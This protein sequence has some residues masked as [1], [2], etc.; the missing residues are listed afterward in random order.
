MSYIPIV[1]ISLADSIA[2]SAIREACRVHG[3]FMITGHG[4]DEHYME[5]VFEETRKLFSL[6]LHDKESIK[7]DKNNRGW[8]P[9]QEE[10]LDPANQREGDT[11]EGFYFG[12]EV[13]LDSDEA[14]KPLH[15][16]NVW[17]SPQSLPSLRTTYEDYISRVT[18]LGFKLLQLLAISLDLPPDFFKPH[19]ER[20]MLML[21]PL[22][23]QGRVSQPTNGIFGA[24]AH[25]DYGMLTILA[26]DGTPGLQIYQGGEWMDVIPITGTFIVN[27]GDM[28]ERWTN[29]IYK[30]TLHR[31]ITKTEKERYSIAFF[32]EPSFDTV[33]QCLPQCLGPG[34][35][36]H[37]PSTTAG[38]HLLDKYAQTHSGY[39]AG[40]KDREK[41]Q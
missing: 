15:G 5:N 14:S 12:R 16:P 18:A 19:F 9:W 38:Q 7:A 28:L 30:S 24:G 37:Y 25:T 3:F 27:L 35:K 22:H 33:V 32:F 41:T 20:P 8:T 1:D 6:P 21:R 39:D 17:P 4:L 31:V 11:K 23:Y 2:A 26:T 34:E 40:Q 10:T 36:P 13:S 29:K